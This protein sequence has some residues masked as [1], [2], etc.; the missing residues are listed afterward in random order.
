LATTWV[1]ISIALVSFALSIYTFVMTSRPPS[2]EIILPQQI[3]IAQGEQIGYAYAYFAPTLANVGASEQIEVVPA[4]RIELTP[5][6]GAQDGV[7][8][9]WR[10]TGSLD[11][12]PASQQANFNYVGDAAPLLLTRQSAASPLGVFFGPPGFYLTSGT[13]RGE[14]VIERTSHAQPLRVPFAFTLSE[15]EVAALNEGQGDSYVAFPVVP[16]NR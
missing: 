14:L 9:E 16:E 4:M 6:Q 1:P 10:Q 7:A 5:P 13:W 3:R 15:E 11:Y 8:L 2:L 12:D